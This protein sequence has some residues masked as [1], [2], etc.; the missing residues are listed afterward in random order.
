MQ[1][2][3][4]GEK[5]RNIRIS[6]G[7]TQEELSK[8]SE[9]PYTTITK[10]E[11]GVIKN[12]TFQ[13]VVQIAYALNIKV[14]NLIDSKETE[15]DGVRVK[16]FLKWAGGKRQLMPVIKKFIP[17]KYNRY[18][19]PFLG[20]GSVYFALRP[21]R[22]ILSDTNEELINL[23]KVIASDLDLLIKELSKLKNDKEFYYQMREL[24]LK[25][26]DRIKRAA[27]TLFLNKTCFNGLYRVNKKGEFNVPYGNNPKTKIFDERE[28][29]L[30]S[31]LLKKADLFSEDF[32][33]ILHRVEKNDL[34]FL[35][36]PYYPV[37]E[38]SD[39][40]RY[41]KE[42]FHE[43]DHIELRNAFRDL[44]DKGAFVILTNSNTEFI[45]ELYKDFDKVV[46]N[47]NRSIN[48]NGERRKGEDMIIYSNLKFNE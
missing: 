3:L 38:Y 9:I 23:Y 27:R 2:I 40:K 30:A 20:G 39:F 24:N 34:V 28:L 12:P 45:R 19:E 13:K 8:D 43:K 1:E 33:K 21:E 14:D 32:R 4:I 46:L 10:I 29:I 6:R 5:V 18:Y 22:A 7:M 25:G 48:C 35:D 36:P 44:S 37:S 41:T 17:N 15:T 26:K 31:D 42:S 47:T 11:N 16:P